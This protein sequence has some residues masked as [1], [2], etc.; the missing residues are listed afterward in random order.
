MSGPRAPV[1]LQIEDISGGLMQDIPEQWIDLV[2]IATYVYIADQAVSRGGEASCNYQR[3]KD[4]EREIAEV[5]ELLPTPELKQI[6]DALG[7][8]ADTLAIARELDIPISLVVQRIDELRKY[9]GDA[10]NL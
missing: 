9:F 1:H 2:E 5:Y 8:G 6:M 4:L 7:R 3:L 10:G